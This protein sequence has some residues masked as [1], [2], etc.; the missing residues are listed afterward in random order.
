MEEWLLNSENSGCLSQAILAPQV[1]E[2]KKQ[3][4]VTL[5]CV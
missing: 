2:G 3:G 1:E 4:R 5:P